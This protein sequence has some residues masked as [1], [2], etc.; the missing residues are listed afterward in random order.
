MELFCQPGLV[1]QLVFS[2]KDS[3]FGGSPTRLDDDTLDDTQGEGG[4]MPSPPPLHLERGED[5]CEH[6]E[7]EVQRGE[8]IGTQEPVMISR[9]E[10]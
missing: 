8:A 6:Q 7:V 2:S 9:E 10:R 4:H 5:G 3:I 1:R